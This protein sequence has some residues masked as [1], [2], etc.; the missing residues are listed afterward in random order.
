VKAYIPPHLRGSNQASTV[1]L[2]LHEDEEKPDKALKIKR[3]E[4]PAALLEKRVKNIKKVYKQPDESWSKA[5]TMIFSLK[6]LQQIEEL[7]KKKSSGVKLEVNQL[8]KLE[9]ED[10]LLD[11]LES[12]KL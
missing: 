3:D 2:K 5:S 11:E 8:E 4:D 1:K 12:L 7:K 9:T 10:A 6:K